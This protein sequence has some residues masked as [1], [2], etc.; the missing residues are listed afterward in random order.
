MKRSLTAAV[1]AAALAGTAAIALPAGAAG[2]TPSIN[3]LASQECKDER[4]ED[5]TEFRRDYRGTNAAALARCVGAQKNEARRDCREERR[6]DASEYK[7][8]FGTG[9]AALRRCMI[10]ELR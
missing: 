9:S 6:E 10:D 5:R 2:K 4:R 8:D 7:R 3:A 1:L